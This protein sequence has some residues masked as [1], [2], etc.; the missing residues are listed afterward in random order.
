VSSIGELHD[1]IESSR[2]RQFGWVIERF[3]PS[4]LT[5][6]WYFVGQHCFAVSK[7]GRNDMTASPNEQPDVARLGWQIARVFSLEVGSVDIVRDTEGNLWPLDVN[8]VPAFR[9]WPFGYPLLADYLSSQV[10]GRRPTSR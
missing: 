3:I 5:I 8:V 7:H 6:K 2:P 4:N 9:V 1:W 10:A